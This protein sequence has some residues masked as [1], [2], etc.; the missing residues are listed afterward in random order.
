MHASRVKWRQTN[1]NNLLKMPWNQYIQTDNFWSGSPKFV[2]G[3][4]TDNCQ[5]VFTGYTKTFLLVISRFCL[6]SGKL[7]REQNINKKLK[8]SI[9]CEKIFANVSHFRCSIPTFGVQTPQSVWTVWERYLFA[10]QHHLLVYK[11]YFS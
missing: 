6:L 10:F 3:S 7:D 8:N 9:H 4:S 5:L 1:W 2:N 11:H